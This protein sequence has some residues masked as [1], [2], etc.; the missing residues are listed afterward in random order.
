MHNPFSSMEKSIKHGID[1][2]GNDVKHGINQLGDET[3][4]GITDLG[5]QAES[6][7]KGAGQ[8]ALLDLENAGGKAIKD[9]EHAADHISDGAEELVENALKEMAKLAE[10]AVFQKAR[11][12]VHHSKDELDKLAAEDPKLVDAINSMAINI[13]LGPITLKYASFYKR[14]GEL[15]D[16]L[17]RIASHPPAFRR[18][19]LIEM[20]GSLSPTSVDLGLSVQFALV[21]GSSELGVGVS[22]KEV[23]TALFLRLGDR[24]LKA[25]GV[26][27]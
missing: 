14:A 10:S 5:N 15:A 22:F 26:P 21:I 16:A 19:S 3:K 12:L 1:N 20:V 18:T 4:R 24:A 9:L 17:D 25:L 7:L 11:E 23:K 8:V 2:L 13:K 27:E 6:Q